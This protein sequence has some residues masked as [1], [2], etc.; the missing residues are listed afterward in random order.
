MS[1]RPVTRAL[2]GI[3]ALAVIAVSASWLVS[4]TPAGNR[5]LD[6]TENK[7]HTLSPGTREI[8]GTLDA[9]VVIRYY[10]SRNASYMPEELKLH[11][12]R[13]D[14][15]L[16]E[17]ALLSHGKLRVE[18]LDPQPDTD[19]EDSARLDGISGQRIDDENLYFGLAISCLDNTQTL[20]FLD[21]RDETMLEYEL[22]RRIADV[23]APVKPVIGVM[24]ALDLHA[25]SAAMPGQPPSRGWMFY[26][27]L[28]QTYDVRDIGM[29]PEKIDPKEIKTLL[30]F[31][32]ADITPEA[33]FAIDQYVLQ[34]GTVIAC[35]D[36]FSVAAQ[37]AGGNPMMG[38]GAPSTSTLPTLLPAWGVNMDTSKVVGDAKYATMLGGNRPGIAVL[39]LPQEAMP[40]K[41]SVV[42]KGL[43]SCTFFLPGAF[44]LN[45][46]GNVATKILL[47]TSP[48][49][50]LIDPM[51]ASRL[52]PRLQTE[53]R[54]AGSSMGLVLH[55][56]G[57]FKT[58]FPKG[59]PVPELKMEDGKIT[60]N[61][62]Q[63]VSHK[64]ATAPGNVFLFPDVDAFFDRFAYNVQ[65]VG[66][67]QMVTPM[68]GNIPLLMNV[69]DQACGSK[70]LIGARSRAALRRPFTVIQSLEANF[71]QTVGV[72]IAE[73][74]RQRDDAQKKLDELQAQKTRGNELYLS[75]EQ[76]AEIKKLQRQVVDY[77]KDVRGLEK[78][79][80]RKKDDLAGTVTLLTVAGMP[81]FITLIGL[82]LFLKRRTS[83]RAR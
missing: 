39:T 48:G 22:S 7:I 19:A 56:T 72:K 53:L 33:E 49:A 81:G 3:A 28:A 46:Q 65:Q 5:G 2:T 12:R 35:V 51:R 55:L 41:D 44:T 54:P 16:K 40:Q 21:P 24:S 27:Q 14:D 82:T 9:P 29:T 77:R 47:Q 37:M 61:D 25:A 18:T 52:D 73:F 78:D 20:A 31:H 76:E 58:A 70:A 8:L 4:L 1:S 75:P 57:K 23:S 64:E 71:N 63:A 80:R 15:L 62:P 67:A 59:K 30:V 74:E 45:G 11:M 42:T 38:G 69:I 43:E 68:N 10:A 60:E 17:Y 34:G 6:F 26:Q 83:T 32:P 36:P 13:V 79:L 50:G 66:A